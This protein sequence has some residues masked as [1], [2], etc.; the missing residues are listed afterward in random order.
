MRIVGVDPG[1][2]RTGYGV[3][4]D[5]DGELHV[6][7]GGIVR[8]GDKSIS[9][10]ERLSSIHTGIYDLLEQYEP[11]AMALEE[12]YSHYNHPFTAVLMGHARGVICLA[13]AQRGVPV[14]GYAPTQVKR[15]LTGNGR[16]T[17]SQMQMSITARLRLPEIPEPNDVADALAMAVCHWQM[18]R[19]NESLAAVTKNAEN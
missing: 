18:I 14:F 15:S 13:A 7:E 8:G 2:I 17:K 5:L 4:E 3:V 1:M 16:A 9:I 10:S 19:F 11:Q 12:L 6:L